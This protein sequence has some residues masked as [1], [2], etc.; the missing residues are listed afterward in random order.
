MATIYVA[1]NDLELRKRGER[2]IVC[3]DGKVIKTVPLVKVDGIVVMGNASVSTPLVHLFLEHHIPITYLSFH[4]KYQGQLIPSISKNG[5]LRQR[6]Y[7]YSLSPE[8]TLCLA[9][10]FVRGKLRNCRARLM[11]IA[12]TSDSSTE[13]R[14]AADEIRKLLLQLDGVRA[15]DELRGVEGL[16]ARLYFGGWKHNLRQP[17]FA[18]EGRTRRPPKDPINALL[19]LGYALLQSNVEAAVQF[20]GLDPYIGYLHGMKH[21]KPSL[22]LD[23]ME[24]FRPAVVDS[25]VMAVV[26][27][28][29]LSGKHFCCNYGGVELTDTGRKI[30]Y[31]AYE[32]KIRTE[33][34]HPLFGKKT[35]LRRCMEQQARILAKTLIGELDRYIPFQVR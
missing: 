18:F 20:V 32:N 23:L 16:G 29:M 6:Q 21:G 15:L 33:L 3:R 12:R 4:G 2:V 10:E 30:F 27:K 11:R 28:R 24:E 9:R 34:T 22:V 31:E 8:R 17:G 14:H 35:D 13:I 19:S 5:A 25:L 7:W 1:D 26:N